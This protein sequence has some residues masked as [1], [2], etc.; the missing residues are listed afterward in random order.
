MNEEIK[1]HIKEKLKLVP[2]LPGSYQMKNKDGII[3][4][5]GKAKNLHNRVSS[6]FN[7]AHTGKTAKLVSEIRD[8]E[9]ILTTGKNNEQIIRKTKE[10]TPKEKFISI[11]WEKVQLELF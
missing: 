3:I 5:V 8:F 7:G 2:N 4:C 1:K 10:K 9:Y 6:Y 11:T